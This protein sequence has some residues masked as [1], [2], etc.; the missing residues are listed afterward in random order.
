MSKKALGKG[1]EA[2]LKSDSSSVT[3]VPLKALKPNDYQTRQGFPEESLKELAQSIKQKGIIQ[4]VLVESSAKGSGERQ[5]TII[6]GE[7]RYRAASLAGLNRIPVIVRQFTEL[8]KI[9]IALIEN[10][11]REDLTPVE[12]ALAYEKLIQAGKLNQEEVA[13]RVG[14]KRSTVANSL[15]LLKL[16]EKMI[17]SLN[18]GTVTPGHARALLSLANPADQEILYKQILTGE[19][20]VREAERRAAGMNREIRGSLENKER[21][22]NLPDAKKSL[23]LQTMEQRFIEILGTRVTIKGTEKKGRIEI[24]YFSTDDLERIW[25][26]F[27]ERAAEDGI[28]AENS[29]RAE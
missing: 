2:L 1:I 23:E 18:K 22:V 14:K 11:Q 27:N 15:R 3:Y 12:E 25:S 28:K 16:P 8:E 4:P 5:Y 21:A 19:L 20:S 10:L 6:A 7:R 9:E 13:R 17:K 24:A 29:M 26:L